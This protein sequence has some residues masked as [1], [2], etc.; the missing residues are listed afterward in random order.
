MGWGPNNYSVPLSST[1]GTYYGL[2]AWTEDSFKDL[3]ESGT[4]MPQL[5]DAGVSEAQYQQMLAEL[6]YSFRA[7]MDHHFDDVLAANNLTTVE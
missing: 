1:G 5:A 2:H 6:I 4:Y 7:E 3:I